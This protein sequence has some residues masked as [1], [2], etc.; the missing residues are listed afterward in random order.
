[1]QKFWGL[2]NLS[3]QNRFL[4]QINDHDLTR[5]LMLL[6]VMM[7]IISDYYLVTLHAV[8]SF[9]LEYTDPLL[10]S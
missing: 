4:Y 7:T 9:K 3:V 5:L 6:Y 1:M 8:P 2:Q 10:S